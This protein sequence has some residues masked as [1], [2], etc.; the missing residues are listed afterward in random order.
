MREATFGFLVL[1]GLLGIL[2]FTIYAK[3]TGLFTTR[4]EV[5]FQPARL[6]EVQADGTLGP[7]EPRKPLLVELP[8]NETNQLVDLQ[9]MQ[10]ISANQL[11]GGRDSGEGTDGDM[12]RVADA[13][14]SIES[15]VELPVNT[16]D[17][18]PD[19]EPTSSTAD[20][21]PGGLLQND[22][23]ESTDSRVPLPVLK[24][25]QR[26][27]GLADLPGSDE[28]ASP[29]DKPQNPSTG[30]ELPIVQRPESTTL[31]DSDLSRPSTA[32]PNFYE[33]LSQA[34]E[35]TT[36]E[37]PTSTDQP[38]TLPGPP[39]QLRPPSVISS[40]DLSTEQ[41]AND[42][43]MLLPPPSDRLDNP[44]ARVEFQERETGQV[45]RPNRLR[46]T[47]P[48]D[49]TDLLANPAVE[50][51]LPLPGDLQQSESTA[52]IESQ[53]NLLRTLPTTTED[54]VTLPDSRPVN[55]QASVEDLPSE[56]R[57]KT[58]PPE[59]SRTLEEPTDL[60]QSGGT[61]DSER[62]GAI[63]DANGNVQLTGSLPADSPSPGHD[64][65]V[66]EVLAATLKKAAQQ[67]DLPVKEP[68]GHPTDQALPSALPGLETHLPGEATQSSPSVPVLPRVNDA[69][70]PEVNPAAENR[71]PSGSIPPPVSYSQADIRNAVRMVVLQPGEGLH[72]IA[73][74]IYGSPEWSVPLLQF[75]RKRA[76]TEGRFATG[77]KILVLPKPMLRFL[78]PE[79]VPREPNPAEATAIEK[80]AIQ[81]VDFQQPVGPGNE[82]TSMYYLTRGGETIFGLAG[83]Y[84][85]Q[86]SRYT[87]L[88]KL[89][90]PVLAGRW[91]H[92]DPLPAGL[93][94]H[95]PID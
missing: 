82:P 86:A 83:E 21:L 46:G 66:D 73:R 5:K 88:M 4:P 42:G 31:P 63:S 53:P 35:E 69:T 17:E 15:D 80:S 9:G 74:R 3:A 71:V 59:S 41:N 67:Y 79:Y 92:A 85:G 45:T 95:F 50:S 44:I 40:K 1:I 51:A 13:S 61:K 93:K 28:L 75:N 6:V 30:L 23:R 43:A 68:S 90:E 32:P 8:D 94:I 22:Q 54:R 81:P 16:L 84:L 72:D 62:G 29:Q 33:R 49:T 64:L 37:S 38:P 58:F 24:S 20:S 91:G 47:A 52:V 39:N 56:D 12:V 76:S 19:R 10:R 27:G 77:T 48:V 60:N 7:I 26:P 34:N 70:L 55:P 2:A 25:P 11:F 65:L 36:P 89:N 57:A 18:I 14:D 87:E 78:Y